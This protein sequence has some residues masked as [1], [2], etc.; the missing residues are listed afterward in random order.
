[1]ISH[2]C[3]YLSN[4][5]NTPASS[6]PFPSPTPPS[7]PLSVPIRPCPYPVP[8]SP[9]PSRSP[10]R[11]P[12][13][14]SFPPYMD[15]TLCVSIANKTTMAVAVDVVVSWRQH[16]QALL[17][18]PKT[19]VAVAVETFK[20]VLVG[21]HIASKTPNFCRALF[22]RRTFATLHT[23]SRVERVDVLSKNCWTV[24]TGF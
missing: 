13:L 6:F 3:M 18:L 1:M 4:R 8:L 22:G 9:P 24:W 2:P 19:V 16:W 17:L 7:P 20:S 12:F 14:S 21:R 15:P 23:L 11:S 10:P 5:H